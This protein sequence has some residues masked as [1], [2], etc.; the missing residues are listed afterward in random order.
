MKKPL[1]LTNLKLALNAFNLD[2]YISFENLATLTSIPTQNPDI[3]Y[4]KKELFEQLSSE[5]KEIITFI[6]KTPADVIEQ[7]KNTKLNSK[8]NNSVCLKT[9]NDKSIFNKSRLQQYSQ[10]KWG[11]KRTKAIMAELSAYA[12]N[13]GDYQ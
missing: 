1:S 8:T 10:K 5:T 13:L 4:E 6:Y 9:D 12:K 7:L 2:N 11:K 3:I